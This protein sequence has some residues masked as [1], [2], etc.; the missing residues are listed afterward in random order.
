ML[1]SYS[2][3]AEKNPA[4]SITCLSTT[5]SW[6]MQSQM[7]FWQKAELSP[8]LYN[9]LAMQIDVQTLSPQS[10]HNN[11]VWGVTFK[12]PNQEMKDLWLE[13]RDRSEAT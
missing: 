11:S 5:S 10:S 13:D 6:G 12:I 1:A 4:P 3:E 2:K 7:W 8:S 9:S